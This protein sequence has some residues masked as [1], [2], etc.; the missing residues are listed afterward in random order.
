MDYKTKLDKLNQI[1]EDA[2]DKLRR[3]MQDTLVNPFCDKYQVKF[4]SGMG[5]YG[6]IDRRKRDLIDLSEYRDHYHKTKV[7]QELKE[8]LKVLELKG[9][10]NDPCS[11]GCYMND[12]NGGTI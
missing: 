2:V 12:Y 1:F 10:P 7:I 11:I 8:L 6:F 3:H 5:G 4:W 9:H